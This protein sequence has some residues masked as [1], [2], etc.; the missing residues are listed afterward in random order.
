MSG[1]NARSVT[2][3]LGK[4]AVCALVALAFISGPAL[5]AVAQDYYGKGPGEEK[6]MPSPVT[7]EALPLPDNPPAVPQ[8]SESDKNPNPAKPKQKFYVPPELSER[9]NPDSNII[10]PPLYG[11]NRI[12]LKDL[13]MPN[14]RIVNECGLRKDMI[15][16]FFVDR[17]R[18]GGIPLVSVEQSNDLLKDVVAVVSEPVIMTM[19]DLVINCT[20]WIQYMVTLEFTF[21]VPPMMYRRKVPLL[22]WYDGMIVSSAKSTHNG[23]VISGFINLAMRFR[24]AWEAQHLSVDPATL[25]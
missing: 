1:W 12:I 13:K 22:L 7:T 25:E 9:P 15:L 16:H 18:E 2:S 4:I 24:N 10:L 5:V 23:A 8:H 20:S 11:W 19:R 17:M 14:K 3:S 21:R 6:H